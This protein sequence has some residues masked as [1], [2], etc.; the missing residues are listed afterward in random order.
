MRALRSAP[1]LLLLLVA[2]APPPSVTVTTV[3][4]QDVNPGATYIGHVQSI[5]SVQIVARVTAFIDTEPVAQGSMVKAG[6]PVFELQKAQ[7]AA[8]VQAA[9][10]QLDSANAALRNAQRVYER[11]AQLNNEGFTA[12]AELDQA[13]ATRDQDQANVLAAQAN[14][15]QA[16]LNLGYCTITSPIDGRIG[17]FTLTPGNLV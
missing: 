2:A 10:A 17:V 5:Q 15:A 7:Y 16:R 1:L 11:A 9:Q 6:E 12:Q 8:A 14:L 3:K 4:R 13:T